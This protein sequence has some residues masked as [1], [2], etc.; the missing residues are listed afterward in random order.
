M[1]AGMLSI[2]AAAHD[3]IVDDT[4]TLGDVNG[5]GV[6]DP[7]DA[8]EVARYLADVEGAGSNSGRRGY[9]RGRPSECL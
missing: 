1:L 9:G 5:D 3:Y 7:T 4:F 6:S 8:L 2:G